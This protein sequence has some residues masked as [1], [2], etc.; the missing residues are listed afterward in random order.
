MWVRNRR[1]LFPVA[2]VSLSLVLVGSLYAEE[3][4]A[5]LDAVGGSVRA[6]HA[7][8][9]NQVLDH[10]IAAARSFISQTTE[11]PQT[12]WKSFTNATVAFFQGGPAQLTTGAQSLVRS[13]DADRVI[14][15]LRQQPAFASDNDLAREIARRLKIDVAKAQSD[16]T[17]LEAKELSAIRTAL[18]LSPRPTPSPTPSPSGTPSPQA[19][20]SSAL[21]ATAGRSP[22]TLPAPPSVRPT[23]GTLV[24]GPI[25]QGPN[26]VGGP[27]QN[28]TPPGSQQPPPPI[29]TV[30]GTQLGEL[31]TQFPPVIN[32]TFDPNDLLNRTNNTR[33]GNEGRNGNDDLDRNN[34]NNDN[35]NNGNN[36]QGNDPNSNP[37]DQQQQPPQIPSGSLPEHAQINPPQ[38]PQIPDGKLNIPDIG[39][40]LGAAAQGAGSST[41]DP[42]IAAKLGP[43]TKSGDPWK[44]GDSIVKDIESMAQTQ[45]ARMQAVLQG[46]MGAQRAIG[47]NSGRQSLSQQ[48]GG[49]MPPMGGGMGRSSSPIGEASSALAPQ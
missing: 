32:P 7:Q 26:L 8:V 40:I 16:P 25:A 34:R 33:R 22:G 41:L 30:T 14:P 18:Q 45:F 21:S 17:S 15:Q 43:Q 39:S 20:P 9:P 37:D 27:I 31:G 5:A 44:A 47:N 4:H 2:I 6:E 24:P 12:S 28:P 1:R 49:M 35:G 36:G 48:I 23:P 3:D 13:L 29:P 38:A 42:G 11:L 19:S 10:A 46:F